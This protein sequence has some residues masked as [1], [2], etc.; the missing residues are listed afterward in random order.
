[1][2]RFN[3]AVIVGMCA[4]IGFGGC[5]KKVDEN[6]PLDQVREEAAKMGVDDLRA[7]A[8]KYKAAIEDKAVA[9]KE[10]SAKIKDAAGDLLKGD[11]GELAKVKE[12]VNELS[13]KVQAL[14]E[15]LNVYIEELKKKGADVSGLSI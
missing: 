15:R 8:E 11:T 4:L 7:M 6:K 3:L 5:A 9:L 2:K 12:K 1:M 13:A 10:Q 14:T